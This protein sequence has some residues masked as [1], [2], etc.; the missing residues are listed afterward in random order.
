MKK[1]MCVLSL[2]LVTVFAAG[3][4]LAASGKCT[5]V[6]VEGTRMEIDCG[7]NTQGFQK[8]NKIKIKT[9]KQQAIEGC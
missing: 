3:N 4:L 5:I 9:E 1:A 6:K 2:V 8:G 7:K